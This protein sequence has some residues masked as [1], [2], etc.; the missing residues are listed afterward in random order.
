MQAPAGRALQLHLGPE[1]VF[2]V[3]ALEH[4]QA[5]ADFCPQEHLACVAIEFISYGSKG[6]S[7]AYAPSRGGLTTNTLAL[8]FSAAGR[9]DRHC[10]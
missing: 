1:T 8:A 6:S 9:C 3:E 2:S 5:K 7:N 10:D 4:S